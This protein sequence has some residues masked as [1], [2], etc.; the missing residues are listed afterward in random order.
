VRPAKLRVLQASQHPGE[1]DDPG[2]WLER[3]GLIGGD[4]V[5]LDEGLRRLLGEGEGSA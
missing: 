5:D 1:L 2:R 4:P 3:M